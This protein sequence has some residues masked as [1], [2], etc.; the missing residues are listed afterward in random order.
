MLLQITTGLVLRDYKYSDL[1]S[2]NTITLNLYSGIALSKISMLKLLLVRTSGIDDLFAE[3]FVSDITSKRLI[4][5]L[6][7]PSCT[8]DILVL[9]QIF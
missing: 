8:T 2:G 6:F 9:E 7:C 5:R 1:C 4:P 3:Y